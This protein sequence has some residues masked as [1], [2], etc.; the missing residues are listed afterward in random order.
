MIHR[1]KWKFKTFLKGRFKSERREIYTTCKDGSKTWKLD[2]CF[3]NE[4]LEL[5]NHKFSKLGTIR[6]SCCKSFSKVLYNFLKCGD[7]YIV[8]FS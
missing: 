8:V 1:K 6:K 5:I 7:G 3:D 2:H 4:V